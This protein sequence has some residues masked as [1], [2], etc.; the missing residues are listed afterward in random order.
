MMFSRVRFHYIG[1]V[2]HTAQ[3]LGVP[4]P[5]RAAA[6]YEDTLLFTHVAYPS[7]DL[8]SS[9]ARIVAVSSNPWRVPLR[10]Y[11]TVAVRLV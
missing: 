2:P 4:L 7:D 8:G 3:Y 6:N 11:G 1:H 5:R 9:G 10:N